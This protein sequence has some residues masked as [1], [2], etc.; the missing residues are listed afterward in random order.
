MGIFLRGRRSGGSGG[1][2]IFTTIEEIPYIAS[3]KDN[4]KGTIAFAVGFALVMLMV[5]FFR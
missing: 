2:L 1:A 5:Y 4:D 3:R